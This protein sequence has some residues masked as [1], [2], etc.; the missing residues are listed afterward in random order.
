ML[1]KSNSLPR[2]P[3]MPLH[4]PNPPSKHY[5]FRFCTVIDFRPLHGVLL[6][7]ATIMI[8]RLFFGVWRDSGRTWRNG[9]SGD[10][11]DEYSQLGKMLELCLVVKNVAD[12]VFMDCAFYAILLIWGFSVIE[13]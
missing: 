11:E 1:K 9:S 7:N 10:D 2:F 8:T 13:A 3:I 6:T 4:L 12:A 5:P